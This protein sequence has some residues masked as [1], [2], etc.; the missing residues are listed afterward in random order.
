MLNF[1]NRSTQELHRTG[2]TKSIPDIIARRALIVL[3]FLDSAASLED[4]RFTRTWHFTKIKGLSPS[5]FM[6][7][8]KDTYW[9][10]FYWT[11][12]GCTDV[13]IEHRK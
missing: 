3:D 5:R 8:V 11:K 10:T 2:R 4:I 6:V 7:Q 12:E 9:I 1:G 13:K